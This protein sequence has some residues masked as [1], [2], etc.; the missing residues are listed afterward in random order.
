M[1]CLLCVCALALVYWLTR[2]LVKLICVGFTVFTGSVGFLAVAILVVV[3]AF[4]FVI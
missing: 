3:F 1:M 2:F 4:G